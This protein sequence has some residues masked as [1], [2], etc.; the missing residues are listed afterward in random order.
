MAQAWFDGVV[1][2]AA[3]GAIL[4]VLGYGG[5]MVLAGDISAGDLASFLLY[6]FHRVFPSFVLV[7][8]VY[9]HMCAP[10]SKVFSCGRSL[11]RTSVCPK[12]NPFHVGHGSHL[13]VNTDGKA[14]R[15]TRDGWIVTNVLV[16]YIFIPFT[17]H[18]RN[19]VLD[20]LTFDLIQVLHWYETNQ[21]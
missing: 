4:G 12:E 11:I 6:Y 5:V 2:T 15:S 16:L 9:W 21:V 19:F 18:S 13:S 17:Y 20:I 10:Y 8:F 1:H 7:T 3:N 14:K